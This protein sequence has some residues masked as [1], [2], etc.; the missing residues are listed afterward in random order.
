MSNNSFAG[1]LLQKQIN[2]KLILGGELF[3][4]GALGVGNGAYTTLDLGGSYNFTPQFSILFSAGNSIA[5]AQNFYSY[6][7]LTWTTQ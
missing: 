1:F 7:G 2:Q 5:G 3:Y 6:V 4:Q